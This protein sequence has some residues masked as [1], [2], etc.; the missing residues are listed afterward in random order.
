MNKDFDT[1]ADDYRNIHTKNVQG[2]SGADSDYFSEYKICEI[3]QHL[4]GKKILD[5]GCGDGNSARFIGKHIK[6][7]EYYGI[8]ISQKSIEKAALRSIPN[9]TFCF[10]D[11]S[12]IPFEDCTFDIV[13]VSCVFHHINQSEHLNV[14]KEIHRVLKKGGKLFVFEHNPNNPL[15]LKAVHDCPFDEGVK[16]IHASKM[17]RSFQNSGFLVHHRGGGK[18]YYIF[19]KK[20]YIYENALS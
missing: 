16:L 17:K 12:H 8:D 11:G 20:R 5:F 13:F 15:T 3:A 6:N 14:L 7:Y 19:S 9:T 1:F 2:M 18:I 10:Y 4:Q